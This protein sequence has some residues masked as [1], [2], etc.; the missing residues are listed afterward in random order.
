MQTAK[1]TA[2]Q[3]TGQWEGNYGV[4][5]TFDVTLSDGTAGSV[6]SKSPQLRFAIGDEV[7]YEVAGPGKLKLNR[8]NPNGGSYSNNTG[9]A[10][11]SY[12]SGKKDYT[13]SNALS[14]ACTFLNG[15]RAT[16]EQIVELAE[17]LAKWLKEEPA[18]TAPAP[19]QS[20]PAA[21]PAAPAPQ[22]DFN[23][24]LRSQQAES[25]SRND[26]RF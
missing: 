3:P 20:A 10:R 9:G 8:P 22:N 24:D 11:T 16:K 21:A 1:V 12:S 23:S 17:Y 5:Y 25:N 2:A 26:L 4:M 13:K 7:E 18:Q 14:S 6:N 19:Q 15:T